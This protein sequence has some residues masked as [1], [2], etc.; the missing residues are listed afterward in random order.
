MVFST[1]EQQQ[2]A[3]AAQQQWQLQSLERQSLAAQ[4]TRRNNYGNA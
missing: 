4:S 1:V 2:M 3:G